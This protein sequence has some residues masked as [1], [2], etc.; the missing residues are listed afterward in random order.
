[1]KYGNHKTVIDGITFDSKAEARRYGELLLLQKSGA[2]QQLQLQVPFVLWPG[3]KF[4]GAARATP[5]CKYVADFVYMEPVG[6][7]LL[8]TVIE[9][10]KGMRTAVY[11]LKKHA[12][13]ALHG[14]D[15]REI[16]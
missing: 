15:V 6:T 5:A 7:G 13:K 1:M 11:K 4:P 3:V 8:R 10:V 14:L 12:L 2:I 16:G 9:D